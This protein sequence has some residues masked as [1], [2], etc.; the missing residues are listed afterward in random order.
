MQSLVQA[1]L[2]LAVVA[3][4]AAAA[5]VLGAAS[6]ESGATRQAAQ[7]HLLL[8]ITGDVARFKAQTGQDSTVVQAFLGWGQGDEYGAPFAGLLPRL[9]PIP[10]L[11]LGVGDRNRNERF[12]PADIAQGRGD[13]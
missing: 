4:A 11:H 6:A 9:G 7:G 8:G 1:R 12:S 2:A 13:S 5:I 3:L 10:M